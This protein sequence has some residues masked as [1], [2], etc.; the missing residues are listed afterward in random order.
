MNN[1]FPLTTRVE[2]QEIVIDAS[3]KITFRK[4][5]GGNVEIQIGSQKTIITASALYVAA[6]VMSAQRSNN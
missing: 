1:V 5:A 3:E 4:L 2:Q 6:R